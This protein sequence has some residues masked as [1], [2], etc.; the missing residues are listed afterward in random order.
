MNKRKQLWEFKFFN[1]SN[2]R[3]LIRFGFCV[4]DGWLD[5]LLK[6]CQ[7]IDKMEKPDNF[8]VVQ[9]KQKFGGLRFY[10]DNITDEIAQR[11]REAEDESYKTCEK[12]SAEATAFSDGWITTLCKKCVSEK[13][14]NNG[15]RFS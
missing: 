13:V 5:L 2:P 6:L 4:G 9:V 1:E 3:S 10:C 12:C 11:I 8:E 7:D 15:C 14:N